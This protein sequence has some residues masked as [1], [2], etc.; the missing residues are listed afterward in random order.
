MHR[1]NEISM[2][3]EPLLLIRCLLPGMKSMSRLLRSM[4]LFAHLHRKSLPA[5]QKFKCWDLHSHNGLSGSIS[6]FCNWVRGAGFLRRK[7]GL[8]G[9]EDDLA[10]VR[11]NHLLSMYLS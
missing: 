4:I 10:R 8:C 6:D 3:F 7:G 11:S 1:F 2:R 5:R 9:E